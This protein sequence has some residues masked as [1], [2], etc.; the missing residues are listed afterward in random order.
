ME[1]KNLGSVGNT[2][3]DWESYVRNLAREMERE[4]GNTRTK[5][6]SNIDMLQLDLPC[7]PKKPTVKR[8]FTAPTIRRSRSDLGKK[9]FA[10]K[11]RDSKSQDDLRD[12]ILTLRKQLQATKQ[13]KNKM[14]TQMAQMQ[15]KIREKEANIHR[16]L[17]FQVSNGKDPSG[18]TTAL[19]S[20]LRN[21]K[22]LVKMLVQKVANLETTLRKT[23]S[24]DDGTLTERREVAVLKKNQEIFRERA[25]QMRVMLQSRRSKSSKLYEEEINRIGEEYFQLQRR[26]DVL[27]TQHLAAMK[28]LETVDEQRE[29]MKEFMQ[30]VKHF[31]DLAKDN[32]AL[33]KEIAEL[34]HRD[35]MISSSNDFGRLNLAR[36]TP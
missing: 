33:R 21:E 14:K 13:E 1:E 24:E 2:H 34:K 35:P 10:R 26:H 30:K 32:V 3:Q 11:Y 23:E 28:A 12:E 7:L 9:R 19:A 25:A 6:T 29:A 16:I 22:L 8:A 31:Q 15:R 4:Q 27:S 20:A 5:Q 17:S 36:R 18:Y